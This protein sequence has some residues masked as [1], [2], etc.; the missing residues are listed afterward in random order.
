MTLTIVQRHFASASASYVCGE[1]RNSLARVAENTAHAK[2]LKMRHNQARQQNGNRNTHPRSH[3]T[4]ATGGGPHRATCIGGGQRKSRMSAQS[5]RRKLLS[6]VP[7]IK[8][9]AVTN[10]L[11]PLLGASRDF[12]T[13]YLTQ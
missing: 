12:V 6:C 9:R 4:A 11:L 13:L 1:W 3:R 10:K 8:Y 7:N 5:V 2:V